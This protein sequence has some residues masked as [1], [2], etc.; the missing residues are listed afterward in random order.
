VAGS[1]ESVGLDVPKRAVIG[2][3]VNQQNGWAF[4]ADGEGD[5]DA[6]CTSDNAVDA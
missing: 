1:D 2:K 4:S 3:A 6:A 5:L